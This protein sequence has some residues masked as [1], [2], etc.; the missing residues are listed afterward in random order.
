[1]GDDCDNCPWTANADQADQ[2]ADDVGD[3]CQLADGSD[4]AD[5]DGV[6]DLED[7]CPYVANPDQLDS[8]GGGGDG[9]GDA[10]DNCPTNANPNQEDA[11]SDT[12]GDACDVCAAGDDRIDTDGDDA[13]VTVN[14]PSTTVRDAAPKA[15]L[16]GGSSSTLS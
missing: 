12:A 1:M 9:V 14:E 3:A 13:R 16:R 5:G 11:D 6:A 15:P 8:E 10:C 2:P 4:D 7:N